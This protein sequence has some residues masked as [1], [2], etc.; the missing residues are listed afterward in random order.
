MQVLGSVQNFAACAI[1]TVASIASVA[2]VAV[3][4]F[5]TVHTAGLSDLAKLLSIGDLLVNDQCLLFR[6][7]LLA[8]I[9]KTLSGT[10]PVRPSAR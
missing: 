9:T 1:G 6:A 5:F 4:N 10:R 2:A 7:N 8:K 3:S